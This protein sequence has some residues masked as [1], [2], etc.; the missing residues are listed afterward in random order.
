VPN[1]P[2]MTVPEGESDEQNVE[3]K[4]W[5]EKTKFTF[6]PKDHIELMENL[7]MVDFERGIKVHGFRGYF[8]TGDG[9]ML[10]MAV[11]NYALEFWN[12]KGFNPV[13]PPV[14]V[15]KNIFMGTGYLPTGEEDLYKTQDGD[16]LAGTAEVPLMGLHADEILENLEENPLKYL[17]FL[18]CFV[19][20]QE[21]IVKM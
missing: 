10:A 2:D 11:W 3:I 15:R 7:K 21:H 13:I 12:K 18:P 6:E 16:F 17:G 8:L 1:I 19:V 20:K 14:V 5:G 4:T 9:V